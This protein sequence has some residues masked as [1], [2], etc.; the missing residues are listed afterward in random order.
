[1]CSQLHLP[2]Q[3]GSSSVLERMQRG[4]TKEAYL[5]L[6]NRARSIIPSMFLCYS[7]L[8][9]LDV[10]ISSDFIAG[11]CGETEE[12]HNQTLALIDCVSYAYGFCFPFS[13]RSVIFTPL[14]Y[15]LFLRIESSSPGNFRKRVRFTDWKM[16]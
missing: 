12:D 13:L 2:A 11:F 15:T 9:P 3:S 4:Y 10:A 16:T 5:E 6:V 7:H 8:F 1:M 14:S